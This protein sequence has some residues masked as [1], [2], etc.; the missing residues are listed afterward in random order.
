MHENVY[1]LGLSS[2]SS[3]A[4]SPSFL[5]KDIIIKAL[6][7]DQDKVL[8]PKI[9]PFTSILNAYDSLIPYH[10][11]M[12]PTYDDLIFQNVNRIPDL[13]DMSETLNSLARILCQEENSFDELAVMEERLKVEEER[14]YLNKTIDYKNTKIKEV[15]DRL[16]R[17]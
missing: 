1:G 13:Q 17:E 14:Y 2:E 6:R 3:T 8:N 10:I 11:F 4:D 7:R 15:K 9:R 5:N 16:I 12:S